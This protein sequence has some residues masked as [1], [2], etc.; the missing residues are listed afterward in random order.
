MGANIKV[1]DRVAI[2]EGV[3]ALTGALVSA[4][5]LR[6]GAALIIAG[7]TAQGVTEVENIHYIDRG[8]EKIEK[9][10]SAIGADI[11]R[12]K[13]GENLLKVISSNIAVR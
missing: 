13:D 12:L 7:L 8:Y 1:E 10:L 4:T 11:R 5:D 6:A 3:D 9:K 2:V